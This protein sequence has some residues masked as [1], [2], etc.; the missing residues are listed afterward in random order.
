LLRRLYLDLIGIPPTLV[1]QEHFLQAPST[2]K[3]DG[4]VDE[5]L[6][7]PGYGERWARHWLDVV[8]YA[9]SNGYERDAEK[10]FGWRYRDYVIT[11]LN[12]DKP[13]DR[14]VLEQLAG[15]ELADASAETMIATGFQRLGHWDDEPADPLT[16]RFDQL[17]DIVSTTAQAFLGL[18]L[19]CARCHD[20][21]FEPFATRDYYSMVAVFNPLQRPQSGRTELTVPLGTAKELSALAER[22][23]EIALIKLQT[24]TLAASEIEQRIQML[25][26]ATPDLPQAYV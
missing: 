15:D 1:E 19:G 6:G 13:F 18:T 4:I 12:E 7:R 3:L 14:F 9:D 22:E 10:P 17:D 26:K 21:K 5:L 11:A 23:H 20:H 25:A 8:R 2:E 16:D 24:N